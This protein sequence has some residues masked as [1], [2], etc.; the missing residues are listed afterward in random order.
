MVAILGDLVDHELIVRHSY[1]AG[2]F[3]DIE[4]PFCSEMLPA[5][6]HWEAWYREH[7]IRIIPVEV[8]NLQGKAG[9]K[10]AV[11]AKDYMEGKKKGRLAFLVSRNGFTK[12]A[13]IKLKSFAQD[14]FLILPLDNDDLIALIRMSIDN[15]VKVIRYLRRKETMLYRIK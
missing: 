12:N 5:F 11:Q 10:Y 1:N 9:R 7:H 13:L 8:K 6:P 15:S 2:G 14:G 4:L 3:T